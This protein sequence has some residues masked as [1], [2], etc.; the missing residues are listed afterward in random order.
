MITAWSVVRRKPIAKSVANRKRI[1]PTFS[2]VKNVRATTWCKCH[3]GGH[4]HVT[5]YAIEKRKSQL[6]ILAHLVFA[7]VLCQH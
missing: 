6:Q 4:L 3:A 1:I 2:V 5:L 7:N